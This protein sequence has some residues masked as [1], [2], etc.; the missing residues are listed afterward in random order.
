MRGND[1][2]LRRRSGRWRPVLALVAA[3]AL[4][5]QMLLLGAV[6]ATQ[7]AHAAGG[8]VA[9]TIIC[10]THE[11]LAT[12]A[13]SDAPDEHSGCATHCVL[14]AGGLHA[15]ALPPLGAS[16]GLVSA[17]G[18]VVRWHRPDWLVS[19]PFHN[20]VAQPRGPPLAA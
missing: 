16:L 10:L 19:G 18:E 7:A 3:Y 5:L 14:C 2:P 6:G 15:A 13:P 4:V 17:T 8:T 1:I 9:D 12:P 20:S 11:G